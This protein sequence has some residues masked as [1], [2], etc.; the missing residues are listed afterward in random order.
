[1]SSAY[2]IAA[3]TSFMEYRLQ[4]SI[5][6]HEAYFGRNPTS[7]VSAVPPDS[8][9]EENLINV[10]MYNVSPN[11]AWRN[12]DMPVRN[13]RGDKTARQP[14]ALNLHYLVSAHSKHD[15]ESDAML[16]IVMQA[17]H[18]VPFISRETLR[19][20]FISPEYID[21]EYAGLQTL[22]SDAGL[23]KQIEQVKITPE[24]LSIEDL[25][26]LW[27]A[28]QTNYRPS[29][30]YLATVV[31]IEAEIPAVHPLPVLNRDIDVKPDLL[32][33][34]PMINALDRQIVV[35]GETVEISGYNLLSNET[36]GKVRLVADDDTEIEYDLPNS[37]NQKVK[38]ELAGD[39]LKVALYKLSVVVGENGRG[40]LESNQ[41]P[42][43]VAPKIDSIGY[44]KNN[45][46]T[47]KITLEVTPKVYSSQKVS[48]VLGDIETL[49]RFEEN[50]TSDGE[51]V[52]V[53]EEEALAAGNYWVRLRVDG[54]ESQL[55]NNSVT[56]PVF[57]EDMK[58]EVT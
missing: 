20:N 16:G 4:K 17:L 1:M 43:V 5:V 12:A 37:N 29:I 9:Q 47:K 53:F 36:G 41:Q 39:D 40:P 23:S 22:I 57:D 52:F 10:F 42:L 31:L 15:F 2:A 55:I 3:V 56:P 26:K 50:V 45:N 27:S 19:E 24:Y 6:A 44:E 49:Y 46:G 38:F 32:P 25:S 30:G 7:T 14:L 21:G 13:S 58:V 54:I 18:E 28:F 48:L 8:V 35:V 11:Q 33:S 51:L 34:T